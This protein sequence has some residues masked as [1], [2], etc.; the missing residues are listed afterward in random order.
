MD[1]RN[2]RDY[3]LPVEGDPRFAAYLRRSSQMGLHIIGAVEIAAPLLLHG[4]R[5]VMAPETITAIRLWQAAA[6]MLTGALTLGLA[7]TR[8]AHRRA[9]L[10][11]GLSAW[12]A[13]TLLTWTALWKAGGNQ[14]PDDYTLSGMTLAILTAAAPVPVLP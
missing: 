5:L 12:V 8:W 7:S 14:G 4:G 6:M 13:P 3:L 11:A 9:R 10:L 2:I 1:F